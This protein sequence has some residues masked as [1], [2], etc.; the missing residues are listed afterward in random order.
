MYY[1]TFYSTYVHY[2]WGKTSSN[3]L[4]CPCFSPQ[5]SLWF[6]SWCCCLSTFPGL[7]SAS[8]GWA[9]CTSWPAYHPSWALCSITSSWTTRE[10]SRSTTRS[11][12]WTCVES[13]WSTRW[14][15]SLERAGSADF[16]TVY[17][18]AFIVS[19][20]PVIAA[21]FTLR[22][23]FS[24]IDCQWFTRGVFCLEVYQYRF[25]KTNLTTES[26]GQCKH[27]PSSEMN[28]D[29]SMLPI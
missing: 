24:F 17:H 18:F 10:G 28:I 20:P 22:M 16:F 25:V 19:R 11:S 3:N 27:D 6:A 12:N 21:L 8:R 15:S 5:A 23:E 29:P 14:V 26:T 9:W 2:S 1:S 13:A 4:C 7:R